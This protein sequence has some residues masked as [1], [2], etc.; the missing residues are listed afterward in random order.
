M[1]TQWLLEAAV[2]TLGMAAILGIAL[3]V[4]R[5]HQIRARR[6]A[7]L[8]ALAGALLMPLLVAAHIGPRVL[9]EWSH[10][11]PAEFSVE[12]GLLSRASLPATKSA[13]SAPRSTIVIA[14]QS[15]ARR[16]IGPLIS[17]AAFAIY[18][19]VAVLLLLRLGVGLGLALRL[20]SRAQRIDLAFLP[21]NADARVSS[22]LM[23]PATIASSIILPRHYA[24]WSIATLR[25]VLSHEFAHVRQKD[26]YVQL[27]AGVHCALFWF[28]P[29]SWWLQRQLSDLGEALSDHAASQQAE[30][31][32]SYA[33]ILLGFASGNPPPFT[34]VAM[35]RGSNL[36]PRIERLLSD[37][38]FERAFSGKRLTPI[39]GAVVAIL[40]LLASTSMQRVV[41]AP[42]IPAMAMSP[43]PM[44]EPV[45]PQ[46]PAAP[47]AP[48]PPAAAPAPLPP[49]PPAPL[50]IAARDI[51]VATVVTSP[52]AHEPAGNHEFH[53][54]TEVN[55]GGVAY[56]DIDN[57]EVFV[58]K[59]GTA[60]FMFNGDFKKRFGT[61][62][63]VPQGDFIFYQHQGKPYVIQDAAILA[64][65]QDLLAPLKEGNKRRAE[66]ERDRR[67]LEDHQ[68]MLQEHSG[69]AKLSNPEFQ[70]A[71]DKMSKMLE[72][73]KS[74]QLTAQ[75]DQKTLLALQSKLAGLQG[76]LGKLQ[77]DIALQSAGAES[78]F[79][80]EHERLAAEHERLGGATQT[81]INNAQRELKPLIEQAINEGRV[82]PAN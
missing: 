69:D 63:P 13:S 50:R 82:K 10:P 49:R 7:W 80:V 40:A 65:A 26:F 18:A 39:V 21:P 81:I 14:H 73:M 54:S 12:S 16:P 64:R 36:T 28:N 62:I 77:A 55:D 11:Q 8:L 1:N 72:Q 76:T 31:R 30:S 29:F 43:P 53:T 32:A 44:V 41:A 48:P 3:S 47:A 24:Q 35:A 6:T 74:E 52:S 42:D 27:L 4:L 51:K 58:F 79:A 57:D 71:V 59:S 60:R 19:G 56:M 34:A 78:Q 9:P 68:K 37:R 46:P 61:E 15:V 45:E 5:I 66:L 67:E 75:T 22:R 17:K 23:N 38:G 20:K 70:A 2:R 33:E 25:V